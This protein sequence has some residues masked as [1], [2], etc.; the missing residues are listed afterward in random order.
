MFAIILIVFFAGGSFWNIFPL[1]GLTSENFAEL[2]W[3][4]GEGTT[5]GT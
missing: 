1:R 5:P 4:Q 3:L 2:S